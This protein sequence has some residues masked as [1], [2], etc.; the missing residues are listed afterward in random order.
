MAVPKPTVSKVG[1]RA[2]WLSWSAPESFGRAPIEFYRI[3][4]Q[5]SGSSDYS[6]IVENGIA[7]EDTGNANVE[8]EIT[9]LDPA[10]MYAFRVQA[11]NDFGD[12]DFS[13]G[14]DPLSPVDP[15]DPQIDFSDLFT[16][17]GCPI[18]RTELR[19]ISLHQLNLVEAHVTRRLTG[20]E[21]WK[22]KRFESGQMVEKDLT[23]PAKAQLYD[24]ATHVIVAATAELQLS[25]VEAMS[26]T[27]QQGLFFTSHS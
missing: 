2:I 22:V 9:G 5:V 18:P 15:Q 19:A 14:T 7:M 24:V 20:G 17:P 11:V 3:E 27:E 12:G 10:K 16:G 8:R 4:Q 21:V 6:P 25:L 1:A 13:K 26:T 23:D